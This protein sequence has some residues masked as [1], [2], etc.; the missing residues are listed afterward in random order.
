ME[1]LAT[2]KRFRITNLEI[3]TLISVAIIVV[4]GALLFTGKDSSEYIDKHLYRD[5]ALT[6]GNEY[7]KVTIVEFFDPACEACRAY[8]PLVKSQLEL[9]QG[10]VNLILRPVAFHRNVGPVVAALTAT[11]LQGKYWESVTTALY[12]QS[13]W[14][15][16]HVADVNL[17][18]PYLE[19]EGVNIE[20]LKRDMQNPAIKNSLVLDAE[21]AKALKVLKT[22]TFYVNG[23][24]LKEFGAQPLKTLIAD[25]VKKAYAKP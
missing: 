19:K 21:D 12:Y 5:H 17:L 24:E 23:I 9:Y 13:R 22:P 7:A 10:K 2:K 20:Q 15:I 18:Y 1:K 14:A 8:Y 25:E 6:L 16:N 11:K 4:I 3:I